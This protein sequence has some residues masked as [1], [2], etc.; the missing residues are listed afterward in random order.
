MKR[1]KNKT[2]KQIPNNNS[3]KSAM[4]NK[5]ITYTHRKRVKTKQNETILLHDF[6]ME[7]P[8]KCQYTRNIHLNVD[9]QS[10]SR[11]LNRI[12]RRWCFKIA[13]NKINNK[14]NGKNLDERQSAHTIYTLKYTFTNKNN[15]K[16]KN[17]L[18][19]FTISNHYGFDE[20][21]FLSLFLLLEMSYGTR[22][23]DWVLS[24]SCRFTYLSISL[25]LSGLFSSM[26]A[27]WISFTRKKESTDPNVGWN[28]CHI[29]WQCNEWIR[30]RK[31]L[32]LKKKILLL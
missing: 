25:Y 6:N 19:A 3:N 23:R 13:E 20:I 22:D 21:F 2:F 24:C 26:N 32:K 30:Q 12:Y 29:K 31:K 8:S 9:I 14:P 7:P 18:Y 11:F 15:K 5:R 28:T 4:R 10:T 16:I 17:Q 1:R 27:D